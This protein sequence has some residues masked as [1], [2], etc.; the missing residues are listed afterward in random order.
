MKLKLLDDRDNEGCIL[1]V[2]PLIYWSKICHTSTFTSVA[3][4]FMPYRLFLKDR[5]LGVSPL[6]SNQPP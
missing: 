4:A 3:Q 1:G 6:E 2:N 5:S